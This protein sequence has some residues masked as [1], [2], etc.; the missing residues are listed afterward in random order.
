[1][2]GYLKLDENCPKNLNTLYKK[3]YCYLCRCLDK[4]Y[5][6][7]SR[8]I[9]SYDVSLFLISVTKDSYLSDVETVTCFNKEARVSYEYE[10]SKSIAALCLLLVYYKCED[11]IHDNNSFKAKCVKFLYGRKFKKAKRDFP[12]MDEILKD[13]HEKMSK[14]ENTD[15]KLETMEDM[16][17]AMMV[18]LAVKCFNLTD[19]NR[20]KA[21]SY[22]AKWL[23][24]IDALDDLDDD[25]EDDT[26][27]Y[28]KE[29]SNSFK[30]LKYNNYDKILDHISYL[31][32]FKED[33]VYDD[34][35]NSMIL[36]RMINYSV[37]DT[38]F[39]VLTKRR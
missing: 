22:L 16:F 29:W 9:L 24:F 3:N 14:L 4:H 37:S 19:V 23:Y 35:L 5:G 39:N 15:S 32:K 18:E 7:I 34:D 21:L 10:H 17:S 8:F 13:Y 27:N 1:M 33:I 30:D 31:N 28:L 36:K 11:D 26:F 38:N 6:V 20:I 12:L 2:F 25:I